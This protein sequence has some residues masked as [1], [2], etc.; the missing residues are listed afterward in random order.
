MDLSPFKNRPQL[1]FGGAPDG[2]LAVQKSISRR[3]KIAPAFI[4]L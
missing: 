1:V 2:S 3:S 4:L